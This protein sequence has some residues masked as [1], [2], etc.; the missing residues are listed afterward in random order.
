MTAAIVAVKATV[1]QRAPWLP[2]LVRWVTDRPADLAVAVAAAVF[3]GFAGAALLRLDGWVTL[4]VAV[5]LVTLAYACPG[6]VDV[7]TRDP[8]DVDAEVAS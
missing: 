1:R 3:A 5:W 4:V 7:F 2:L 8:A 6:W